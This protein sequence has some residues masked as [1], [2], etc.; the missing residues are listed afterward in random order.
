[1]FCSGVHTSSFEPHP[2]LH[3][4]G[5]G[6]GGDYVSV[7]SRRGRGPVRDLVDV[8]YGD[9]QLKCTILMTVESS[10]PGD[11]GACERDPQ[12]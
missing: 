7:P 4:A 12:T 5:Y 8:V 9:V 2:F 3:D 6:R 1:M 10:R 11:I